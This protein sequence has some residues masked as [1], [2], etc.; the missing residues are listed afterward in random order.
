MEISTCAHGA[1]ELEPVCAET[2]AFSLGAPRRWER[3]RFCARRL[4]SPQKSRLDPS[5]RPT[6]ELRGRGKL[7]LLDGVC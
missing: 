3:L 4:R 7:S 6:S 2:S 1:F 5:V